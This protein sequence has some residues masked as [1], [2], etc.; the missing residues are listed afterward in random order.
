MHPARVPAERPVRRWQS[1]ALSVGAVTLTVLSIYL[2]AIRGYAFIDLEVYRFGVRAWLSGGDIYGS[3]PATNLGIALPFIY[4]PFAAI[5]LSPMAL[6]PLDPAVVLNFGLSVTALA[7][8]IYLVARRLLP[9]G[10][11]P[12]LL[13]AGFALPLALWLE[14]VRE[15]MGFGQINLFLMVLVAVDCLVERPRWPRG[16]LVGIAAAIKLTPGVFL[17][18]FLVRKDFRAAG[19]A[20]LSGAAATAVGFLVLPTESVRYWFGGF[21]GAGGFS[22]SPYAMNQTVQAA[23][24]RFDLAEGVQSVLWMLVAL[25]VV[26]ASAVGIWRAA[27]LGDPVIGMLVAGTAGLLLSPTSWSHHWVWAAPALVA[28]AV[29]AVR[30]RSAGWI[31]VSLLTAAVCFVGVHGYLPRSNDEELRWNALEQFVGDSYVLLALALLL[32]WAWPA[33]GP[34]L[35]AAGAAAR[36]IGARSHR[37]TT[38]GLPGRPTDSS[39]ELG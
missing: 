5:A 2:M 39:H 17:L 38:P 6:I 28:F 15:T 14:P 13:V 26:G 23:L 19:V 32:C 37:R 3:L 35:R 12:A 25:L 31:T 10:R 11:L 16:L 7:V 36:S 9:G 21:A 22:G 29:Y 33:V 24:A 27:R 4:P 18:Y 1:A 8:T 30:G 34:A 20:V